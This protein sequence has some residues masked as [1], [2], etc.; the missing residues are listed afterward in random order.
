[1]KCTNKLIYFKQI[2]CICNLPKAVFDSDHPIQ[3][4]QRRGLS[5]K[6]QRST[7]VNK[8]S[9]ILRWL[10]WSWSC[11]PWRSAWVTTSS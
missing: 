6:K 11:P 8:R 7:A 5:W 1:M 4:V 2:P 10:T 3:A 9:L